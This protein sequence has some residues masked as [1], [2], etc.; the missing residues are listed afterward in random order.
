MS[1]LTSLRPSKGDHLESVERPG[2]S[3]REERALLHLSKLQF[4]FKYL[5]L[6]ILK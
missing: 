4:L 1:V 3:I 5:I 2:S 6:R